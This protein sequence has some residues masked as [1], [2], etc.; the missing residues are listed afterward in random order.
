M[1]LF[2]GRSSLPE[3]QHR[4][5]IKTAK[6]RAAQIEKLQGEL[7]T[8]QRPAAHAEKL[9][10][11]LKSFREKA[12]KQESLLQALQRRAERQSEEID[13]L[14]LE[15][16]FYCKRAAALEEENRE[17]TDSAT[18]YS[19]QA[20]KLERELTAAAT[21]YSLW[22]QKL[23]REL[24]R[25]DP[26]AAPA[27][28]S[29]RSTKYSACRATLD[30]AA[31]LRLCAVPLMQRPDIAINQS[32][33]SDSLPSRHKQKMTGTPRETI[34]RRLGLQQKWRCQ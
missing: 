1:A 24:A 27:R 19:V 13:R 4:A 16:D 32:A 17:L 33:R 10:R 12:E 2:K 30:V 31:A 5:L 25:I 18:K 14:T 23:E 26:D 20:Q 34:P 11:E 8:L 29:K 28:G 21:K 7:E 9:E 6:E 22:G 15:R 3:V